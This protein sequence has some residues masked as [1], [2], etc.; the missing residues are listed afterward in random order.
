MLARA[1][2]SR[3]PGVAVFDTV[4]VR[5]DELGS[6][7]IPDTFE[8]PS[9]DFE[10]RLVVV[11]LLA[12][13]SAG[14]GGS[15]DFAGGYATRRSPVLVVLAWSQLFGLLLL[16]LLVLMVGTSSN[17]WA[18][19]P[20]AAAA[21][22]ALLGG[23]A[24]FY[25]ALSTGKMAV[26]APIAAMGVV[27][28]LAWAIV[29]GEERPT[30]QHLAGIVLAV[31]GI[32]LGSGPETGHG[33]SL[34]PLLLAVA[35]G[36]GFGLMMLLLSEGSAS[37]P[38]MTTLVLRASLIVVLGL[39][40]LVQRKSDLLI[41]GLANW[42]FLAV[43]GL[44]DACAILCAAFAMQTG[45]VSLAVV[46]ASLYPVATVLLARVVLGERMMIIQRFGVMSAL[47]GIVLIGW[48]L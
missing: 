21:G 44:L 48:P 33:A 29:V 5:C 1:V 36:V 25:T 30:T 9:I 42:R 17:G 4:V 18:F 16:C 14:F 6:N 26:V 32:V 2:A 24:A 43:I 47:S 35:A 41:A 27:I 15:A 45:P 38:L 10:W 19:L 23:L 7:R 3:R 34:R 8:I 40:L 22:L 37:D 28:P 20:W 12:L 11:V 46:L 31:V 13:L 39:L